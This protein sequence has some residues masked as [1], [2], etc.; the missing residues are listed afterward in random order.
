MND[1]Y[2]DGFGNH[3]NGLN[4]IEL[5]DNDK[6]EF[7]FASGI[8]TPSD[9]T[10]VKAAATAAVKT[11][12]DIQPPGPVMDVLF[13]GPVTLVPGETFSKTAYNSGTSYTINE[14][15]PLG[16]LDVAATS[17]GFTYEVTDKRWSYDQVLL[18]DNVST[19]TKA[20]GKWYA[21]VNDVYKDG[22][23]NHAN[24]LN[25]IELV[26]NDKVEFYFASGISTPSDLTAVK[27]AATAA[28][29]TVADIQPPGPVMDVLFDGPV[30]LIPGETFSKTAY[31]SGTSYTINETTP[32][33]ALDVAATSA[34]F[35]Y[36]VTDKRWSYDQVLLLDN[37]STYTKATGKW[38][39]YVNDVYKDGFGNHANGLNVIELVD[40]DK[41]EFY[42]ASGISTPSDLTAV[43]AAATAAVKTVVST[44]TA[45]ADWTL[46]V[47]GAVD[48][49]VTKA[50]FEEGLAC[51]NSGHWVNWTDAADNKWSGIPLWLLVAMVDDIDP[52]TPDHFNFRDDLATLGYQVK[53]TASD[54]YSITI[55]SADMA[56]NDGW[57][58]ANALNG[59]PLP[60]EINGKKSWPL[61]LKGPEVFSGNQIGSIVKIEIINIPIPPSEWSLKIVGDVT[62][63]ITKEEFEDAV[64]CGH[65]ANW[66]DTTGNV[67]SGV[68][69]WWFAGVADDEETESHWTFND[70]LAATNYTIQVV[71]KDGFSG[72]FYS[73]LIKHSDAYIVANTM[74]GAPITGM[75]QP[76]QMVGTAVT[77]G[78]QKVKNISE[79]RIPSLQTPVPAA[80][81]YN[82]NL[83]GKIS[84]IISQTEFEEMTACPHHYRE[85]TV[86]DTNG[87]QVVYSGVPLWDLAGWVDDRIPHG[88]GAFN[89]AQAT[90]GYTI[91]VQSGTYVRTFP[92]TDVMWSDNYIVANMKKN[93]SAGETTFSPFLSDEW[94]LRIVGP[95][96]PHAMSVSRIDTISLSD[97]G[98]PTQIP[99]LRILK[100][101]ADGTTVI[102]DKTV[103]YTWMQANLP[104]IG[105]GTTA[106]KFEGLTLNPSNLWDPEETYPGGF[107]ISNVV[108]G[109]RVHDLAELVGGMGSGTTI[110][111]VASDG[112]ETTL[113]YSSIYTNPAVQARQGD[114]IIAWWGDGQYVPKYADGMRLF[115]TPDG[116]HVYGHWDMHETLPSQYWRY[117][118]QN[119]VQYPSSAGLSAKY[120]TTIKV[121]S[122]P[123][124]DWTLELDGRDIGGVNYT[125]SKPFLE[126]ALACQFGA[127]HKATYTDSKGRVWEGM[128]L[129]FFAGFVDDADQHSANAYNETKARA[130]YNIVITGRRR[131]TTQLSPARI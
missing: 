38:Y 21:Y 102:A 39:A 7:Y 11:V 80:G 47:K 82:L 119:G 12:A 29:K 19:Y 14:T 23:G 72:N 46:Q 89:A 87:N 15:T 107:K 51:P 35:T 96:A 110:T 62:D 41:V 44:G 55:N 98:T 45:P 58:V 68:P 10:A 128:P 22:F 83:N 34:G 59:T 61:H 37:V 66:T 1:V 78:K 105:D 122:T 104:V 99:E 120:I 8:S 9:L 81:K 20:T 48:Q 69:L 124:S 118:F 63:T 4:V 95:G 6:V 36:E 53:I 131:L 13:D 113:P 73:D 109:S 91:S 106:Y 24:G 28:V 111:F 85:V 70:T 65:T 125:V 93:V 127:D 115:F 57:I 18:L 92:S 97:F 40:N 54:G 84:D 17:A 121:Y 42:F 130:G 129:W 90:A 86:T 5:V 88:S 43:K 16:A 56:R 27:A 79:I 31:N 100:Y 71:A 117:N 50:Y 116:D 3:A 32:L 75:Q 64:A 94:P 76:L 2:K 26:D 126:E 33:G 60:E 101:G 108:K 114:A 25:V 77:S 103:N 74:N 49:P 52:H 67:Y 30:T 112:F 123:E